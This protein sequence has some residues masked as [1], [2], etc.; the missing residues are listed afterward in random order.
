M[1]QA[2]HT[3]GQWKQCSI[4]VNVTTK[5]QCTQIISDV[6]ILFLFIF[7]FFIFLYIFIFLLC[8]ILYKL[9]EFIV[10]LISLQLQGIFKIHLNKPTDFYFHIWCSYSMHMI[11]TQHFVWDA[12][13]RRWWRRCQS[14]GTR[15]VGQ[16]GASVLC[17]ELPTRSPAVSGFIF[18]HSWVNSR[19]FSKY[20][21]LHSVNVI[22]SLWRLYIYSIL[23]NGFANGQASFSCI[24]L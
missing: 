9:V 4:R 6:R 8:T 19:N 10:I 21:I 11:F 14:D 18:T 12:V 17:T 22:I 5:K 23:L 20:R 1:W 7:I 16:S 15:H 3:T 13:G 2:L 24:Y